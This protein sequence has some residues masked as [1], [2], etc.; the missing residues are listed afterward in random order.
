MAYKLSIQLWHRI[1]D[2]A[3]FP[4]SLDNY[5]ERRNLLLH[6]ALVQRTWTLYAQKRL[7]QVFYCNV[8]HREVSSELAKKKVASSNVKAPR[9]LLLESTGAYWYSMRDSLG[10][11]ALAVRAK[12]PDVTDLWI[13][14]WR[15]EAK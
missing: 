7:A 14:W 10:D 15:W 5:L 9:A 3:L 12:L 1:I 4:I 11:L 13:S 2:P 8:D 6:L